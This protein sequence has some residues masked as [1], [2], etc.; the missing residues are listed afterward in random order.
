LNIAISFVIDKIPLHYYQ[1]ELLLYS[2]EQNTS[3]KKKNIIVQC[4][5]NVD[6]KFL[7]YL[8]N[9]DYKYNLIE[10]Y[11]DKKYCNK[12]QQLKYFLN[13]DV[14]GVILIDSDMFILE[15]LSDIYGEHIM[16]KI[17]DAPNPMLS[18]LKN[19]YTK[20]S[21]EYPD[22]VKSDWDIPHND[23]FINNFNGGFYY[24]PKSQINIVYYQW[25]KWAEWLYSKPDLF[26]NKQQFIHVDQISFSLAIHSNN[27]EFKLLPSNYNFPIHSHAKTHSLDKSKNIKVLHFHR[28]IDNFGYINNTK[29]TNIDILKSIENAN[30]QLYKKTKIEFFKQFK[31]SQIQKLNITKK[32]ILF[33]EKLKSLT[34]N[35]KIKLILHA[36]TPKT[37]TTSLQFFMDKE[38]NLLEKYK[39]NYPSLYSNTYA[40]KHQ[41]LVSILME[42]NF[43]EL[44]NY[45]AKIYNLS[46]SKNLNTIFLSTEGIYNHWQDYSDEAK[47]ILSVISKYFH[48]TIF[49]FIENLTL[50]YQVYI[51]SI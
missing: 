2:L 17:V 42:N 18:T 46:I 20:A 14:D 6:E 44:Y 48:F 31:K 7:A 28:E 49:Y 23:T 26:E 10:P 37:G 45:I 33:E 19:I 27:L 35:K 30:Q 29:V 15:N 8:Q 21:L 25:K 13:K 16:A 3:Y 41:W 5:K 4:L 47:T 51:N 12:L 43:E 9:N 22:I 40:P 11:L 34:K 39:I 50:F 32:V 36:G 38:R 24:I 1:A